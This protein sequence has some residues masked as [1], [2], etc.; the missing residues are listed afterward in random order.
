MI[1]NAVLMAVR[2]IRRNALRSVLT[3]LGIV[4]GVGAVIALVTVGAGATEKVTAD[5]G[6]LGKNLL[7]VRVGADRRF[8]WGA[9]AKPFS[10]L[11]ADAIRDDIEGAQWVSATSQT[12]TLAIYGNRNWRTSVIGAEPDYFTIRGYALAEGR[13]FT[14]IEVANASSVCVVGESVRK[15]LFGRES[16]VGERIRLGRVS[17]EVVGLL[18]SKGEVAMG[19]DQDDVV[20]LPLPTFQ[21]RIAGNRDVHTILVSVADN[22]PTELV[23]VQIESLLRDRRGLRRGS[24]D[25]FNVRDMQEVVATARGVTTVLTTLLGAIAAV[26]LVVGGVGIMNIML[27]SVTERTREIGIRLAI[28]ARSSDVLVQFLS[29]AIVLSLLGG[30]IGVVLGLVGS[31]AGCRALSLPF[32]PQADVMV[33]AFLFSAVVGVIF[34]FLPARKAAMLDPIEALRRE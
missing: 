15:E 3:M 9:T 34:G 25:D 31:Y 2:E 21:R 1:W 30:L 12:Q 24:A 11:D 16:P 32:V 5:I 10:T 26:S 8:G 18:E 7:T 29:E 17:C 33:L 13:G 28:G 19:G 27:V 4:I 14:D 20:L 6:Q 23:R 22:R